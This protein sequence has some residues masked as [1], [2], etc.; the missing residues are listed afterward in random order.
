MWKRESK[1]FLEKRITF[2][3]P[4]VGWPQPQLTEVRPEEAIGKPLRVIGCTDVKGGITYV[5]EWANGARKILSAAAVAPEIVLPFLEGFTLHVNARN[6]NAGHYRCKYTFPNF[7]ILFSYSNANFSLKNFQF[8]SHA[9]IDECSS[10]A[11]RIGSSG[12]YHSK[13]ES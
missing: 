4:P 3:L 6:V 2:V 1:D 12:A 5:C 8:I 11:Q 7:L 10:V 9:P 13:F